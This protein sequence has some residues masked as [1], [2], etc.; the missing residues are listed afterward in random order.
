MKGGGAP[1]LVRHTVV[2][3]GHR[4]STNATFLAVTCGMRCI[5]KHTNLVARHSPSPL[6]LCARKYSLTRHEPPPQIAIIAIVAAVRVGVI[7]PELDMVRK[8]VFVDKIEPAEFEQPRLVK[9][10]KHAISYHYQIFFPSPSP[11]LA[12]SPCCACRMFCS[13]SLATLQW[14]SW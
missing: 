9:K 13:G 7:E 12:A 10:L 4:T 14:R 6:S 8:L 2:V 5:I 11:C 3:P 1:P